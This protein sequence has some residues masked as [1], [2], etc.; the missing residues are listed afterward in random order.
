MNSTSSVVFSTKRV[1]HRI[2]LI[3]RKVSNGGM[4]VFIA[5]EGEE[6]ADELLLALDRSSA[7]P[8]LGC[9]G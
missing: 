5:V 1:N 3:L 9:C 8:A 4:Q 7:P 6:G 2:S